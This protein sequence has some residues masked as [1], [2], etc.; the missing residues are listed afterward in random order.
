MERTH[1]RLACV[2]GG[3]RTD[4][5]P[6]ATHAPL[7]STAS[8][9]FCTGCGWS[10]VAL[11]PRLQRSMSQQV[12][13]VV[14]L[15]ASETRTTRK[16]MQENEQ[17]AAADYDVCV[18]IFLFCVSCFVLFSF[19]SKSRFVCCCVRDYIALQG[20]CIRL[21]SSYYQHAPLHCLLTTLLPLYRHMIDR[22]FGPRL[23]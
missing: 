3:A 23:P 18:L 15:S 14:A 21:H 11:Y 22:H 8:L 19:F 16:Q 7:R 20:A 5:R 17:R 10:V 4:R 9:T 13:E 6:N 1:Q 12:G 2:L